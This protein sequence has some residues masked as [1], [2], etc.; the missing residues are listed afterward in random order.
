MCSL[1]QGATRRRLSQLLTVTVTS[2]APSTNRQWE[3]LSIWTA[4]RSMGE[5]RDLNTQ[6]LC[7]TERTSLVLVDIFCSSDSCQCRLYYLSTL[8]P[9]AHTT[10]T[11]THTHTVTHTRTLTL[12]RVC[13]LILC[14]KTHVSL[15]TPNQPQIPIAITNR[16]SP[17]GRGQGTIGG[18]SSESVAPE[19]DAVLV[20]RSAANGVRSVRR[21]GEMAGD[22]LLKQGQRE[23]SSDLRECVCVHLYS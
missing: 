13:L 17:S 20:A 10:H 12:A 1:L 21:E 5:G 11:H 22:P 16:G 14:S 6:I 18:N 4:L 8:P 7:F 15:Y 2:T 23:P 19:A 3:H 9:P